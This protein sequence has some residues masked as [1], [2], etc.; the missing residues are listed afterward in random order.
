[1]LDFKNFSF[2][3]HYS[4][5]P[6]LQSLFRGSIQEGN[7]YDRVGRRNMQE[8]IEQ[9][10]KEA[11]CDQDQENGDGPFLAAGDFEIKNHNSNLYLY[12]VEQNLLML[13]FCDTKIYYSSY[14]H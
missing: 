9:A 7:P 3:T 8:I 11:P 6:L 1:M 14:L 13:Y 2:F 4:I 5:T 10:V 12:V